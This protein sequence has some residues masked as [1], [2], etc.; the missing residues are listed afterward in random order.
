ML[1]DTEDKCRLDLPLQVKVAHCT[2]RHVFSRMISVNFA[3]VINYTTLIL[4]DN[5][6]FDMC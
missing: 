6:H 5:K 1:C 4:I 3:D 2:S